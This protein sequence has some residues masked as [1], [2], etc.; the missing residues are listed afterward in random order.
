MAYTQTISNRP[1]HRAPSKSLYRREAASR[2]GC[3]ARGGGGGCRLEAF[4]PDFL[5]L[6]VILGLLGLVEISVFGV[7]PRVAHPSTGLGVELLEVPT[8]LVLLH[9]MEH[10]DLEDGRQVALVGE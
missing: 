2:G 1:S 7:A 10:L 4:G 5:D 6:F 8:H 9:E 3:G